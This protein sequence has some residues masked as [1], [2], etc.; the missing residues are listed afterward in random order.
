M[1]MMPYKEK[2][3]TPPILLDLLPECE[4]YS[5]VLIRLD[6]RFQSQHVSW[7]NSHFIFKC[8][9]LVNHNGMYEGLTIFDRFFISL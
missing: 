3:T 6:T 4:E 8:F 5:P 2:D 9:G 7:Q 1:V